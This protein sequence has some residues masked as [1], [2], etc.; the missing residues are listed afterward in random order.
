MLHDYAIH[1]AINFN[2]CDYFQL[3]HQMAKQPE[4]LTI[5]DKKDGANV[6]QQYATSFQL[7]SKLERQVKNL[8]VEK[9]EYIE[10]RIEKVKVA[11]KLNIEKVERES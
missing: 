8:K 4:C 6:L 2:N 7:T 10:S 5:H 9:V 3:T 1:D 11:R